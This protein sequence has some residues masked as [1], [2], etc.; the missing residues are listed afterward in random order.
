MKEQL[1][2]VI[3]IIKNKITRDNRSISSMSV[4]G[5]SITNVS[6]DG[7]RI[8]RKKKKRNFHKFKSQGIK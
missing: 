6:P 2:T 3:T 8:P 5:S 1:P 7:E 4:H